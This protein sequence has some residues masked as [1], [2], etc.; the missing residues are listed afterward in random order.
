MAEQ[1]VN[2]LLQAEEWKKRS[3]EAIKRRIGGFEDN[4]LRQLLVRAGAI[5]FE[6]E[7]DREL[8]GLVERNDASV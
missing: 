3:F 7:G 2:Q 6:G 4:E 8:W 1:A 5:R